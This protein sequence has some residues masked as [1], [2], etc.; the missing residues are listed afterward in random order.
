MCWRDIYILNTQDVLVN[1][2][3]S[4]EF[5]EDNRH[6]YMEAKLQRCRGGRGEHLLSITGQT[7]QT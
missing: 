3:A 1:I 2:R 5:N 6:F 7:N 4:A